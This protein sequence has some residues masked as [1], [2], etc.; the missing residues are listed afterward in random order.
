MGMFDDFAFQ[1]PHPKIVCSM[2]HSVKGFQTKD[3]ECL[4]DRYLVKENQLYVS[5]FG[6]ADDSE[7]S[8]SGEPLEP[9]SVTTTAN[10]YTDCSQCPPV[11]TRQDGNELGKVWIT[12]HRPWCEFVLFFEKGILTE[13]ISVEQETLEHLKQKCFKLGTDAYAKGKNYRVVELDDPE[14][15]AYLK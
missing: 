2:G 7:H 14:V 8:E 11:Y 10:I 6:A 12:V 9:V 4:L 15:Q 1:T 13:V 3:F 5:R